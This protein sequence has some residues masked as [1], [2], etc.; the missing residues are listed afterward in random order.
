MLRDDLKARLKG[1]VLVVGIGNTLR[2][3]DGFGPRMIERLEGKVSATLLDVGEVPESYLGRVLE[4]KARTILVLDAADIGEAA[5]TA[6]I[7]EGDDLA[8]CN[9]STHQMPLELFFRFVRENSQADVFALGVQ[10]KQIS[11][12][13]EMS[14]EVETTAGILSEVLIELLREAPAQLSGASRQVNS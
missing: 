3:D 1:T 13:S 9:V 10:P 5:G 4:Q 12:G 11:L 14:P 2:G 7:L 6:T 8:G